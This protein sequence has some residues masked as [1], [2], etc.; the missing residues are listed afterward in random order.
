MMVLRFEFAYSVVCLESCVRV[1]FGGD[2]LL[3]AESSPLSGIVL[4]FILLSA[5]VNIK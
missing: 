1:F 4:F 3:E 5:S 2:S